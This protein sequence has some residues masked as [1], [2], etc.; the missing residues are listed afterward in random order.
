MFL[1]SGHVTAS[2]RAFTSA[3]DNYLSW[4]MIRLHGIL[5]AQIMRGIWRKCSGVV[6]RLLRVKQRVSCG[7]ATQLKLY[8]L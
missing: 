1:S 7:G 4:L 8:L 2:A 5:Y 3:D 6:K